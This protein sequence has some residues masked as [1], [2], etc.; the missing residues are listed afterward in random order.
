MAAGRKTISHLQL[1]RMSSLSFSAGSGKRS[2]SLS[3]KLV[4]TFLDL[5]GHWS[6]LR[7]LSL[8]LLRSFC[9]QQLPVSACLGALFGLVYALF[10]FFFHGFAEV[11]VFNCA[12][13]VEEA[14]VFICASEVVGTLVFCCSLGWLSSCLFFFL[15]M[16]FRTHVLPS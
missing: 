10:A 16:V 3:F 5:S 8:D 6:T 4:Q 15:L 7:P 9:A 13:L 12:S 2:L 1:R 14:P 11:I